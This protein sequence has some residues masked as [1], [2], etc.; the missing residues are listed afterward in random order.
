MVERKLVIINGETIHY[1]VID[2][3]DQFKRVYNE[4]PTLEKIS[5]DKGGEK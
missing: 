4:L 2:M 3:K 5:K 1:D